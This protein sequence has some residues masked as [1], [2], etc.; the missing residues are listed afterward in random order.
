M[1]IKST[2]DFCLSFGIIKPLLLQIQLVEKQ[3]CCLPALIFSVIF[4][5]EELSKEYKMNLSQSPSSEGLSFMFISLIVQFMKMNKFKNKKI[6]E[7]KLHAI[8]RFPV[9]IICGPIGGSFAVR[10]HLR[11]RGPFHEAPG[12]YRGG[13]AVL[14]FILDSS[15]KRFENCAVKLS[16]KETKWTSS[17]VKH[18]LLFLKI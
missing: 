3:Y 14:F 16:A 6:Q 17:E 8:P 18:T 1:R 5:S 10:D 15:F 2:K 11:S 4:Q 9:L 7:T 13:W 12:N